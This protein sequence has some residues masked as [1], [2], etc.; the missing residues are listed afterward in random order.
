MRFFKF[1]LEL[2]YAYT[3]GLSNLYNITNTSSQL[4]CLFLRLRGTAYKPCM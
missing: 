2:A 4:Y 3:R 1:Y